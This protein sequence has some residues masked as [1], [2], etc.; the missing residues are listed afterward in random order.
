MCSAVMCGLWAVFC[1][2]SAPCNTRYFSSQIPLCTI[3]ST[4]GFLPNTV[5]ES[6][7]KILLLSSYCT[8]TYCKA[9]LQ[10]DRGPVSSAELDYLL[11]IFCGSDVA[12]WFVI[13]D[14]LTPLSF[15]QFQASS[16]KSLILKVCRGAYPPLPG[17]LPY[18]LRYLVKQMFKT[19]PKDRPSLHTILT[20]HRVFRLLRS[21]LPS[22]VK[23]LWAVTLWLSIHHNNIQS[24]TQFPQ[25]WWLYVESDLWPADVS[26][27]VLRSLCYEFD[28][29]HCFES[30]KG[31]REGGAGKAYRSLEQRWGEESGES[32][33]KHEFNKNINIWRYR[34][35]QR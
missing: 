26:S 16:W 7:Y 1:M 25:L 27:D 29:L 11:C 19:N 9:L 6:M 8:G 20:S 33:G 24:V 35:C 5:N 32:S 28:L 17:H 34:T 30:F 21:H 31:D 4:V 3:G 13:L 18:E 14:I 22:Q 23:T 10:N 12:M 2:S 15:V